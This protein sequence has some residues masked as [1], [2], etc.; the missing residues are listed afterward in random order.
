MHIHAS[1]DLINR[2][3]GGVVNVNWGDKDE[4]KDGNDGEDRKVGGKVGEVVEGGKVIIGVG[5]IAPTKK[6]LDRGNV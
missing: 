4:G 3:G 5:F 1:T 2:F 6:S